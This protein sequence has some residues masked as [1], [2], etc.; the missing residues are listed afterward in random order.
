MRVVL[1]DVE[2]FG[3]EENSQAGV[4]S[5]NRRDDG[6]GHQIVAVTGGNANVKGFDFFAHIAG[7][8]I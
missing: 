3:R 1:E 6:C 5:P 8:G 4:L 2:A 7:N